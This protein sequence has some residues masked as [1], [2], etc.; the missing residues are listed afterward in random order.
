M[1]CGVQSDAPAAAATAAAAAAVTAALDACLRR[2]GISRLATLVNLTDLQLVF[3]RPEHRL[4][5]DHRPPKRLFC[6]SPTRVRRAGCS[7]RLIV[8]LAS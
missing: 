8:P 2:A 6:I 5:S 4:K 7:A 1:N 3:A